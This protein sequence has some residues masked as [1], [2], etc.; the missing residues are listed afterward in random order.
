MK[1]NVVQCDECSRNTVLSGS[2]REGHGILY[3]VSVKPP[4]TFWIKKR[5]RWYCST[6]QKWSITVRTAG[7]TGKIPGA[8]GNVNRKRD[9]ISEVVTILNVKRVVILPLKETSV[10]PAMDKI[11]RQCTHCNT[12]EDLILMGQDSKNRDY[13]LTRQ[14]PRKRWT[15][16]SGDWYC[17]KCRNKIW[18]IS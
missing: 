1:R 6:C 4:V 10:K 5:G 15:K 14:W 13:G 18:E 2:I 16:V 17:Y 7:I 12:H 11:E 8:V 9:I 3:D